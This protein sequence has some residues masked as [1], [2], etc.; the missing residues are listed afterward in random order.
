MKYGIILLVESEDMLPDEV[1]SVGTQIPREQET[2]WEMTEDG[3]SDEHDGWH[4]EKW[5]GLLDELEFRQF[6]SM[7]SVHYDGDGTALGCP[8]PSGTEFGDLPALCYRCG[9]EGEEI[10]AYVV[11]YPMPGEEIRGLDTCKRLLLFG[12]KPFDDQDWQK[13]KQHLRRK[14]LL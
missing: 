11:P 4:F 14:Q 13:I 12:G 3:E 10:T 1:F 7:A 6:L 8:T 2:L 5:C 9:N